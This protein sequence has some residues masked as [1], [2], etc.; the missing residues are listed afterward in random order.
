MKTPILTLLTVVAALFTCLGAS[1]SEP[2]NADLINNKVQMHVVPWLGR[3]WELRYFLYVTQ[4]WAGWKS[5]AQEWDGRPDANRVYRQWKSIF[6][7]TK[8][9]PTR[10]PGAEPGE[11]LSVVLIEFERDGTLRTANTF[12]KA[13]K[14]RL[15]R[16]LYVALSSSDDAREAIRFPLGEWFMGLGDISTHWAPGL[17]Q[18]KTMP[19]PFSDT[20]TGYLYGPK[21]KIS[22]Y[23]SVFGCREWAYQL[24]D[25]DRPYIDVTSYIP[26]RHDPDGPGTYIH[27][28]VGWAGFD[29]HKPIIGKQGNDWYCLHECPGSDEPGIIPDIEAWAARHGWSTP[30]PPTRVPTFPDPPAEEGTYPP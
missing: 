24:N 8:L 27:E 22:P 6:D 20:D 19:S 1:A 2:K 10:R 4:E 14:G 17:C 5:T 13:L 21:F 26:K 12:G 3:P 9:F 28:V 29:D 11:G 15:D 23:R 25:P 18:T 30:K 7:A 16:T